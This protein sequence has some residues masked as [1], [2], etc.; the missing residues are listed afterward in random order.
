MICVVTPALIDRVLTRLGVASIA[1][2]LD[3]LARFYAAWCTAVPFDNVHKLVHLAAGQGAPLPGSTATDF[4]ERWLATRAGGTCWSGNG[5]LH[6]LCAALGFRTERVAATMMARPDAPPSN[7]GS[8]VVHLDGERWIVDASILARVPLR[9]AH[10]ASETLPRIEL[11]GDT[12]V[13]VWRSPRAP[14]GFACRIDRIGVSA[15]EW[16]AC[17]QRTA[18]WGPFN[19]AVSARVVRDTRAIGYV[20]GQRF[21][22]ELD[23]TLAVDAR[24]RAGRDRFLVA[25]L[26]IAP[27]LVARVPEDRDL[28]PEP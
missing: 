7:H 18:R 17:H 13:I 24:D 12:H 4:F 26:G 23:G 19:F 15:D 2:D 14:A 20:G 16:D 8:V 27:E 10:D 6:D 11:R 21:A 3:G 9:L 1:A 5:A 28:P 22:L 25:E